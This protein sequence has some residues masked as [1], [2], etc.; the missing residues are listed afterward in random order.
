MKFLQ[1]VLLSIFALSCFAQAKDDGFICDWLVAGPYPNYQVDGKGKALD[2]DFLK[3]EASF[4]PYP[5]LSG[6]SKFIADWGKLVAGVG[7][8]NE[9]G[10]RET[11][12][13]DTVWQKK[14]A[15][16]F[17]K[18]GVAGKKMVFD[19]M[20]LPIDDY[21]AVYSV[22]WVESP[23]Q[24]KIK[25]KA[26]SD[27]DHRIY[28]NG[29]LVG[30]HYGAQG[31]LADQFVYNAQLQ[32]GLNRLMFKLVDR[33]GGADFCL[34]MTDADDKPMKDVKLYTTHPGQKYKAELF[35][36]GYA[37]NLFFK[38]QNLYTGPNKLDIS[39]FSEN[40]APYSLRLNGKNVSAG[41]NS[42]NLNNGENILKLEVIKDGKVTAVLQKN[43]TAYSREALIAENRKLKEEIKK[44]SS[45]ISSL[46]SKQKVFKKELDAVLREREKIYAGLERKFAKQRQEVCKN[47]KKSVDQPLTPATVRSRLCINGEWEASAD[48]KNW[49]EFVL[50][51]KMF[52]KYFR[53]WY[54]PL[55]KVDPK[56]PHG[57]VI[58]LKGW[59]DFKLHP[60][61]H[62]TNA[63][64]R[65]N[66]TVSGQ[67]TVTLVCGAIKGNVE[68]Y[69]NGQKCGNYSGSVGK[70]EFPLKNIKEGV[71]TLELHFEKNRYVKNGNYGI[72][73]DL[74]LDFTSPV[75]MSDVWVKSSWRKA[76]LSLTSEVE[77]RTDMAAQT[78][79][80]QYVV[81]DSHI[82][83]ELPVVQKEIPPHQTV[84]FKNT[85]KWANPLIW[86]IGGKYGNPDMYDL[87]SDVYVDNKLVDRY[88][89]S[90]GFREFWIHGTDFFLNGKRI[91]LRG[92]V[93]HNRFDVIK[94]CDVI[95]PLFRHDGLNTIRYH[96]ETQWCG[97]QAAAAD[98]VGMLSYVQ[99]YP[100]LHEASRG[101]PSPK[102]FSPFK[103]WT[104][105]A[106][107]Q[108]NLG[109][110]RR[111]FRLFRN[112]PSAVIWSTD[113]EIFTQAWDTAAKLKYNVRNDKVGTLYEKFMKSL[114]PDLVMTRNG[115][116]GTWGHTGKWSEN[117]P[118]D[119]ANYHYP[120]YNV[121]ER[122]DN[123]QF[124]YDY[125]PLIFGETLY[126][127]FYKKP[128]SDSQ[129]QKRAKSVRKIFGMF[130]NLDVPGAIGMGLGLDGFVKYDNTGTG[131]PWGI[132]KD[133]Y[134]EYKRNGTLP[135]GI[136]PDHFPWFRIEWPALSGPGRK[137]V[138]GHVDLQGRWCNI[139][140]FDPTK[141][142][143]IRN[144]INDA[145]KETLRPQPPLKT[146]S[147]GEC[148]IQVE[149]FQEVWSIAADGTR[150]GVQADSKGRAWFQLPTPGKY[151]FTCDN[152]STDI[153]V[154]DKAAYAIQPGFSNVKTFKL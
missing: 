145:Y 13:F 9:W 109:N 140:W 139:N 144:A 50:P 121:Q 110:Y 18:F 141:A 77:N 133:M 78:K 71:N 12:T 42:I 6:K 26:G 59:D 122:I 76:T 88:V 87:V 52:D 30:K 149:P 68:V 19:G 27:D 69:V 94:Q 100:V 136:A 20:F 73:G 108:Y 115:D 55:K 56:N 2:T 134:E 45:L 4:V 34:R 21:F 37:G 126:R 120:E 137:D 107:H 118:C 15:K 66:F 132:T 79:I 119:T 31:T 35:Q 74:Y 72:L 25:L 125:R 70:V 36:N 80:K 3:G 89:Q 53:T 130:H 54:H 99:A 97:P 135:P 38:T 127:A 143:H 86:G 44:N 64:F 62:A 104:K 90:F 152:V 16:E 24:R 142:S 85:E 123:W 105:T 22:C 116:E 151:T 95:W 14:S 33:T 61:T 154:P 101:K 1:A 138:F 146:A 106:E 93:G 41:A 131:N 150:Y 5:G 11:K 111:W 28:L 84:T 58:P 128:A 113:N 47:A 129:I 7:S 67:D 124:L 48:R 117:P 96:G 23:D 148:I 147:G 29:K 8:T 75:K 91:F 32:P 92:D 114:D 65:K 153:E 102:N 63:W 103:D 10:F 60:L 39:V 49:S 81:K 51:T 82:K 43:V 40:K 83:L 57:K 46:K 17:E 112:N 98:R